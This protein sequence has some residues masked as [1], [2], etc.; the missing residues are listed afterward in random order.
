MAILTPTAP[1]TQTDTTISR[2][3]LF[4]ILFLLDFYDRRPSKVWE[5]L[6]RSQDGLCNT[7]IPAFFYF[8]IDSSTALLKQKLDTKCI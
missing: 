4:F 2:V 7:I 6:R 3:L 5:A 1:T 8:I